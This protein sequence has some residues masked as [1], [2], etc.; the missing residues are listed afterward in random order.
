MHHMSLKAWSRFVLS[1]CCYAA[2]GCGEDD[3]GTRSAAGG[4]AGQGGNKADAGSSAIAKP[5]NAGSGGRNPASGGNG[6]N[7]SAGGASAGHSS[8]GGTT[9]TGGQSGGGGGS[10]SGG[11]P[12]PSDGCQVQ[13]K[14]ATGKH[15]LDVGGTN[16][17]YYMIAAQVAEPV[18][19]YIG[20]HG[21]GGNGEA[22]QHTFNL[23]SRAAGKGVFMFPDGVVQEWWQNAIGWDNR[24]NDNADM[25]FV[26][27][28]IAEAKSK[29]CIDSSRIYVTGFSWGGWMATQVA[30][31]LGDQLRGFASGGGG[32]PEN[33]AN[34][35]QTSALIMHGTN[36]G[37]E[38]IGSG[39]QSRDHF[40][41]LNKCQTASTAVA[42]N[43]CVSYAGCETPVW[44][45]E[46][47]GG[48]EVPAGWGGDAVWN[49]FQNAPPQ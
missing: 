8:S 33:K 18:P 20:F 9:S 28:L 27:K 1:L 37:A 29:H 36:D 14:P 40:T 25:D 38:N 34:C 6:G 2:L 22:E 46:H 32:G 47:G 4:S 19:L 16:R 41:T 35:Q 15:T 11:A 21:Y 13:T 49:F 10:G 30:C 43:H 39:R 5:G 26:K 24:N 48:H 42:D 7:A 45:C 44:W 17:T 12:N 31:A 3:A 23:Q